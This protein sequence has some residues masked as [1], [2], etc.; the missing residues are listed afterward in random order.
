MSELS[1]WWDAGGQVLYFITF[2]VTKAALAFLQRDSYLYWPFL[3]SSVLLAFLVSGFGVN[4]PQGNAKAPGAYQ[5]FRSI[6]S[7]RLWWHRSA[8][9]DYRLYFA[10]ALIFPIVVVPLLWS[11]GSVVSLM[12][13][14]LSSYGATPVNT[15]GVTGVAI[16]ILFTVV[17]FVAFD[18]GRFV[19]HSLLHDIPALWPFHKVH[20]SAEVLTPMTSYRV[21]P[22]EMLM[23]AWI[24]ALMTGLVT[25]GFNRFAGMGVSFYS[26]LGL[27]IVIWIFNLIDNLR[28]S[29]VWLSYGSTLGQ[30]LV[31]PAHHQVHHS[32]EPRHWGCNRGSNLAIWD[33]LYGTLYVPGH[34]PETFRMGLGDDSEAKW[35]SLWTIYVQPFRESLRSMWNIG[36]RSPESQ[37]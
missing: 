2:N 4:Y 34:E 10:N 15:D 12:E 26:F 21:H 20:H 17:F 36:R 13:S 19:A 28:H 24:P 5:R 30:W 1:Q 25:W 6:F 7:S 37:V 18:F 23:M 33:R 29:P 11:D 35:H 31:S 8:R 27:H 16:R 32:V 3:V 14:L 9:A 22:I